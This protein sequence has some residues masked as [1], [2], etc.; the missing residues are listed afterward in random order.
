MAISG[1]IMAQMC[2]LDYGPYYGHIPGRLSCSL[3]YGHIMAIRVWI[4]PILPHIC[5][6]SA[7]CGIWSAGGTTDM[8]IYAPYRSARGF[9]KYGAYMPIYM[10]PPPLRCRGGGIFNPVLRLRQLRWLTHV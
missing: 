2:P 3:G 1:H 5:P 8:G 10:P 9:T 6:Y 7:V 4:W